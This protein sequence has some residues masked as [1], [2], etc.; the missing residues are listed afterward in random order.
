MKQFGVL[1]IIMLTSFSSSSYAQTP[2]TP[3]AVTP[4]AQNKGYQLGPE[5][6]LSIHVE[7]VDDL[8]PTSD[9]FRVDLDG[10]INVP[11]IGRVPVAGLTV[12]E[13]QAVLTD[14][15]KKYLKNPVVTVKVTEF[16]SKPVSVLGWVGTPGVKDLQGDKTLLQVI[17][18]SGGLSKDAGS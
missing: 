10:T 11:R 3:G 12:Y 6:L 4:G 8:G 5:D 17:S 1:A 9:P 7:N 16:H 15:F 13:L 2:N 18:E 14:R